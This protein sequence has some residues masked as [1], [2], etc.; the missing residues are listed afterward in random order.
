MKAL[1]GTVGG[2][3]G[4]GWGS[5]LESGQ[6]FP[7]GRSGLTNPAPFASQTALLALL[8]ASS[9]ARCQAEFSFA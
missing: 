9:M 4:H 5:Q 8:L 3:K 1:F 6:C 7:R 2:G